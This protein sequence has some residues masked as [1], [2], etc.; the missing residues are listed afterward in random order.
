ML[1]P[2]RASG[3]VSVT[4][5]ACQPLL[6]IRQSFTPVKWLPCQWYEMKVWNVQ[7]T[8]RKAHCLSS[9]LHSNSQQSQQEF[10]PLAQMTFVYAWK[11]TLV[12]HKYQL[13]LWRQQ[14]SCFVDPTLSRTCGT[15]KHVRVAVQTAFILLKPRLHD[16]LLIAYRQRVYT[17][18]KMSKDLTRS[19]FPRLSL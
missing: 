7:A 16:A 12:V 19:V 6:N 4:P 17:I 15:L 3:A 11:L 18:H 14:Q 8:W 9:H 10:Q 1:C 13:H 2:F 5:V